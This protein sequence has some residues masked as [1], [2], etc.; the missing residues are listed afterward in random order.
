MS[1]TWLIM[2]RPIQ[3]CPSHGWPWLRALFVIPFVA[4][5][6]STAPRRHFSQCVTVPTPPGGGCVIKMFKPFSQQVTALL[7]SRLVFMVL[8]FPGLSPVSPTPRQSHPV[9]RLHTSPRILLYLVPWICLESLLLFP[10]FKC[11]ERLGVSFSD[12]VLA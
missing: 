3:V 6:S 4:S 8:D 12:S 9:P 1:F 11:G 2:V 7:P 5:L 10:V